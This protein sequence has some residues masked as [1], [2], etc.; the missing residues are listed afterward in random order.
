MQRVVSI[1]GVSSTLK[2]EPNEVG[3]LEKPSLWTQPQA[4]W[5]SQSSYILEILT[6]LLSP[7]LFPSSK[8]VQG[9]KKKESKSK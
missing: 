6:I 8:E 3:L 9:K 4:G 2:T 7:A 5:K 1:K